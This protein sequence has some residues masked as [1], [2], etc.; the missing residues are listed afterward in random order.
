[1]S[2]DDVIRVVVADD[3]TV[4]REALATLLGLV[5][6]LEVVGT[7]A[8][9]Q[10]AVAAAIEL[11]PDVVLMD[12]RM[13]VMDGAAATAAITSQVPDTAVVVLTTFADE[14]SILSALSA[15]AR[16]YLTKQAGREDMTRA[17]RA[18]AGGQAVL[19]PMVQERL[20]AAATKGASAESVPAP[21]ATG[22]TPRE[23]D[24][25][26][27]VADGLSNRAIAESLFVSESTVK[28]HINNLFAKIQVTGRAQAVAYAYDHGL[29]G[30]R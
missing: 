4:V 2:T 30:N 10:E 1:M 19:D 11:R 24:V 3:Q 18:A 5:P 17:I 12:L 23:L 6:G 25:L 20:I 28:T 8:D 9:G 27:L 14:D 22:L 16:G 7:A 26:A 21:T 15:G 13:P 29:A